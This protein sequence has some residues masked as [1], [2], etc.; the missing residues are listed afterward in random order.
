MP[1]YCAGL[2]RDRLA[3]G[4]RRPSRARGPGGTPAGVPLIRFRD[5][6]PALPAN[7][8][9]KPGLRLP[10]HEILGPRLHAYW[11]CVG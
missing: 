4:R 11:T 9:R 3:A 6:Y 7:A 5:P 8:W 2:R 1:Y 10:R